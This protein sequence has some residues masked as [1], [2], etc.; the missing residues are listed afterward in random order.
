[1]HD[2]V[3]VCAIADFATPID[4]DQFDEARFI[5]AFW[6][7]WRA[8]AG[9]ERKT[10]SIPRRAP[11]VARCSHCGGLVALK[12]DLLHGEWSPPFDAGC[13]L[14]CSPGQGK[15]G[16]VVQSAWLDCDFD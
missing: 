2:G 3:P 15:E 9:A 1:V 8:I 4:E 14:H 10:I 12:F 7:C 16:Y 6:G 5:E 11:E 13:P